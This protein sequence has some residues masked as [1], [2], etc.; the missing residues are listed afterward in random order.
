LAGQSGQL[1]GAV[2]REA[3]RFGHDYL[4]TDTSCSALIREGED[5]AAQVLVKL[6]GHLH[7]VRQQVI[8]LLDGDR[9]KG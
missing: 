7:R 8:Q 4:G 3:L 6:G 1:A 9:S 2:A 5:V